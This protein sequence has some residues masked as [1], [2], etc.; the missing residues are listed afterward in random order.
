VARPSGSCPALSRARARILRDAPGDDLLSRL[1][2]VRSDDDG[3]LSED[4]VV[5]HLIFIMMA[6]HDTTTS[7]LT[8]I[9][10]MLGAHPDW[11]DRIRQQALAI[12][13]DN[14]SWDSPGV[15]AC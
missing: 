7:V 12:E 3:T 5:D 10:W 11:Q 2:R 4:A 15:R 1:V 8:N 13:R 9:V 6:A 14:L